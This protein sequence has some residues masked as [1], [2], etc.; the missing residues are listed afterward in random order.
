VYDRGELIYAGHVGTGFDTHTLAA[1]HEKL[2][3]IEAKRSPF[4]SVPKVN[5]PVHWVKPKLV[6]EV[7][8]GEWTR[9]GVLRQPVYVGLRVD[10]KPKDT[11]RE[12]S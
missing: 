10:K 9:E 12:R 1:L 8:F 7:K 3:R 11:V 5:S 4:R 2:K 6:A